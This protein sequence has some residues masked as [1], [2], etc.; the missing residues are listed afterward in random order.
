[1]LLG[2]TSPHAGDLTPEQQNKARLALKKALTDKNKRKLKLHHR[3]LLPV[4]IC[5]PFDQLDAAMA[6]LRSFLHHMTSKSSH[7][8]V[9]TTPRAPS[10]CPP[11]LFLFLCEGPPA[12]Q[13][14]HFFQIS[15][16]GPG[17][18][19]DG[20]G[21]ERPLHPLRQRSAPDRCVWWGVVSLVDFSC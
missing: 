20:A 14:S 3:H 7:R 21:P 10:P 8:K 15:L 1:M 9:H 2:C 12:C 18:A 6:M 5:T 17:Q 16:T 11:S 19:G 4:V 13:N